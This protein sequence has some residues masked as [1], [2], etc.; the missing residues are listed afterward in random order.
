[1]SSA[2]ASLSRLDSVL[3]FLSSVT[4]SAIPEAP[5]TEA[6]TVT[7]EDCKKIAD[8]LMNHFQDA[9]RDMIMDFKMQIEGGGLMLY[10]F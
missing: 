2:R 3:S 7:D 8:L 6:H 10:N 1:M 4:E 5:A 9:R